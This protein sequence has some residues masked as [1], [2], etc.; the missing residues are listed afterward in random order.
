MPSTTAST[1]TTLTLLWSAPSCASIVAWPCP[2][3]EIVADAS[4]AVTVATESS[5]LLHTRFST[6]SL[7]VA[8]TVALRPTAMVTVVGD[9]KSPVEL[10]L[11]A[12]HAPSA[13][14][15]ANSTPTDLFMAGNLAEPDGSQQGGCCRCGELRSVECG[16]AHYRVATCRA[17]LTATVTSTPA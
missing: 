2:T 11:P 16:G 17:A 8:V 12:S 9:T 14:A 5:E 6:G 1:T 10:G 4:F 15:T 3:P 13:N 7:A